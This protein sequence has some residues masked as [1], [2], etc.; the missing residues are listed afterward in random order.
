[1][2]KRALRIRKTLA[3]EAREW[4][5]YGGSSLQ[6]GEDLFETGPPSEFLGPGDRS[7]DGLIF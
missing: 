5:S 1:M 3:R 2:K 4:F 6:L 7:R